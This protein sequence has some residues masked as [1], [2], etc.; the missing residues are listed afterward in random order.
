MEK[1]TYEQWVALDDL[2][3]QLPD[4]GASYSA[5]GLHYQLMALLNSFGYHPNSRE[6]AVQLA[7]RLLSYGWKQSS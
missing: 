2:Y 3:G 7:G 1:L 5:S 6:E 4:L